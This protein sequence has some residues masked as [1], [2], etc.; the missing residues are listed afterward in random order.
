M[1]ALAKHGIDVPKKVSIIGYDNMEL[2]EYT[3]PKI[4]SINHL[5][6]F[7]AE[8]ALVKLMNILKGEQGVIENTEIRVIERGSVLNIKAK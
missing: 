3:T 1:R 6:D 5:D 2:C 4:T 7:I 8:K